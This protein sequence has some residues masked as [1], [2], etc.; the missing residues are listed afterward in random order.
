MICDAHAHFSDLNDLSESWKASY[1]CGKYLACASAYSKKEYED[2][3]VFAKEGLAFYFSM[4][5]HPQNPVW[6]ELDTISI[7]ANQKRLQAIGESG[8]DFY[9]DNSS[10][11]E[12]IQ[13][14]QFLSMYELAL[15]NDLP[16]VLHLRKS[17]H[18][19]FQFSQELKKLKTLVFHSYPGSLEEGEALLNRGINAYFSFGANIT[20]GH[21]QAEKA[22]RFL[23]LERLLLESDAP[24]QKPKPYKAKKSRE[25]GASILETKEA[26]IKGVRPFC[27]IEDIHYV[28]AACADFRNLEVLELEEIIEKNFLSV[29]GSKRFSCD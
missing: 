23:P 25:L 18:K 17:M 24:Y 29:F 20:N 1:L 3:L 16:M 6:D 2:A 28:Y 26:K 9:D 4:G 19:V 7:L 21:K 10:D 12:K 27:K 15:K 13:D 11:A 8:W 5:I 14:A 22:A